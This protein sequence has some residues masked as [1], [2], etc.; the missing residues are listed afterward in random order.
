VEEVNT[1][2]QLVGYFSKT[3]LRPKELEGWNFQI[4]GGKGEEVSY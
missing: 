3:I 1:E 2:P 4:I